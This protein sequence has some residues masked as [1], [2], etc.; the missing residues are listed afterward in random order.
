LSALLVGCTTYDNLGPKSALR[1]PIND[2]SLMQQ[3]L[4]ERFGFA[5]KSIKT[6][7]EGKSAENRPTKANI[8]RELSW[9]AES[10]RKGDKVVILLS[11]HGSQQ[12]DEDF[13]DKEDPEPD[14]LD[15][16]FCPADIAKSGDP[17]HP[18]PVNALSDDELRAAIKLIR[19]KGAFVWI[20]V[21]SCHS[22][23]AVRGNEVYRQISHEELIG[24]AALAKSLQ[25]VRNQT[26]GIST[27]EEPGMDM[28]DAEGGMVAMYA[29]QP[30]E[31]TLEMPLPRGAEEAEWRGLLTYTMINVLISSP[32]PLSYCELNQRIH[33][34]YT[35]SYGRLGPT[36]LIEGLDQQQ[37][38]LGDSK[39][40]PRS[41]VFLTRNQ[42]DQMSINAGRLHGFDKGTVF[43]VFPPP[44][45]QDAETALGYIQTDKAKLAS[46]KV[47][48]VSY[49]NQESNDKL[50][51]G[52]RC[53]PVEIQYGSMSLNVF[54]D[55]QS[56]QSSSAT[57][58]LVTELLQKFEQDPAL[59]IQVTTDGKAADWIVRLEMDS[60]L[61]LI[62][63]EGWSESPRETH[64]GPAPTDKLDE[65]LR[66]RL[67]RISRVK[68]LLKLCKVS[69]RSKTS[70]FGAL[71]GAK[72]SC[73]VELVLL[74]GSPGD[75]E[76]KPIQW[77]DRRWKLK[78]GELVTLLVKNKGSDTIDFTVQFIDS[79]AGITQLFPS[80]GTV[81]D[82]RLAP[83][84][85]NIVGPL[86]VE[87]TTL[88]LEH[89]LVI[90]AK[91]EGQPIDFSWLG[92]DAMEEA[93][94]EVRSTNGTDALGD[95]LRQAMYSRQNLRGMKVA[96]TENICL[97][98]LSWQTVKE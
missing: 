48:P 54:L 47:I 38:V 82:N 57:H 72:K 7:V 22:G 24:P 36:P 18:N 74:T 35:Q 64:F 66:E 10:A 17:D 32:E 65:W 79:K 46:S 14:G 5:D 63:S 9:L 4:I 49:K 29:A 97:R 91:A 88:G 8:M 73:E 41:Q 25:R 55:D 69:E 27:P 92:Q 2:V 77:T 44:G 19:S 50:P 26:R 78:N 80:P 61:F 53:E 3:F 67:S 20:I 89:L 81:V 60:K 1:G 34:E 21:D 45:A 98:A 56:A 71:L 51:I 70:T 68:T 30:H 43:A 95:L 83:G 33:S 13:D 31:P 85:S 42:Q 75:D 59:R 40:K 93:P 11:G 16:I 94:Q 39:M 37:Q 28:L 96:D 58:A 6:L 84:Q 12:L 15:E 86:E 23:S 62:P 90:A 76:L 87:A 52:G